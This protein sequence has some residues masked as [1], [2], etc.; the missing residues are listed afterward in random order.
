MHIIVNLKQGSKVVIVMDMWLLGHI[1]AQD[2]VQLQS[3]P[4]TL[5]RISRSEVWVIPH[6]NALT[7]FLNLQ[8]HSLVLTM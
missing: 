2:T 5:E 3:S 8:P 7:C 4:G 1:L 6:T